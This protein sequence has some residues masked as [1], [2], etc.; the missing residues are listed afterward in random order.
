MECDCAER[1]EIESGI[2][3]KTR[4]HPLV[5][6]ARF[7]VMGEAFFV[8]LR[9]M[10]KERKPGFIWVWLGGWALFL[11]LPRYLICAR[12]DGYGEMCYSYYL[13]KYTS[14]LFPRSSGKVGRL[15]LG[16]E[17]LSLSTIFWT[18]V[19]ALRGSRKKLFRYLSLLNL[20]LAGQF[21]H[22]CRYCGMHSKEEWKKVCP[23]FR[24]WSGR[25]RLQR[26]DI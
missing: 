2:I 21:F 24:F 14:N 26:V 3:D 7:I 19:F 25:A 15:G 23:A 16:L 20:V 12:C 17:I 18:P 4:P 10:L 6:A 22:A 11:T 9:E 13:G 8:A 5:M 1:I